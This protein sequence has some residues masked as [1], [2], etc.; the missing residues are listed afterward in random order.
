MK[1]ICRAYILTQFGMN[2]VGILQVV[3]TLELNYKNLYFLYNLFN[4]KSSF[5]G[6]GLVKNHSR[7]KF[8]VFKTR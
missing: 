1:T 3:W 2:I 6:N 5:L 4:I 8:N 7:P